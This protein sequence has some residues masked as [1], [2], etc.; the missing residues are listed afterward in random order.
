[1]RGLQNQAQVGL[2]ESPTGQQRKKK[3]RGPVS[4]PCP[5]NI[6]KLSPY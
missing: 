5:I 4:K 6:S 2:N 3:K 1:V